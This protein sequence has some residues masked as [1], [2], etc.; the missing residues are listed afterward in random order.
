MI[1]RRDQARRA[2]R[3]VWMK[4]A[5]DRNRLPGTDE[6]ADAVLDAIDGPDPATADPVRSGVMLV[7]R[8]VASIEAMRHNMAGESRG[9]S[10]TEIAVQVIRA[11]AWGMDDDE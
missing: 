3:D 9:P 6:L 5:N 10:D 8:A 4:C 2:V 11:I 7:D 1:S